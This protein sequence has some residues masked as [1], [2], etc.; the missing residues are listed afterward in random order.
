M[1][2]YLI[3]Q[4]DPIRML[5]F[6]TVIEEIMKESKPENSNQL[7]QICLEFSLSMFQGFLTNC[8]ATVAMETSHCTPIIHKYLQID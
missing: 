3:L 6:Q 4:G 8:L 2:K 7:F 1:C 5:L